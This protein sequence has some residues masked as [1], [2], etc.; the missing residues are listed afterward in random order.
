MYEWGK[1]KKA[2]G[3]KTGITSYPWTLWR[4]EGNVVFNL[5]KMRYFLWNFYRSCYI[6]L[7]LQQQNQKEFLVRTSLSYFSLGHA[8]QWFVFSI[9]DLLDC[10]LVYSSHIVQLVL[11]GIGLYCTPMATGRVTIGGLELAKLKQC[12]FPKFFSRTG[13][14]NAAGRDQLRFPSLFE[15]VLDPKRAQIEKLEPT[16]LDIVPYYLLFPKDQ[17]KDHHCQP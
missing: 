9:K 14:T 7:Q 6:L 11:Y 10:P 17:R 5:H 1:V 4:G 13:K 2:L 15:I 12:S 8:G 16:L 3:N